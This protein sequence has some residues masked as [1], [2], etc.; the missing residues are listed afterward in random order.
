[1]EDRKIECYERCLDRIWNDLSE[2]DKIRLEGHL[3]CLTNEIDE[4][5]DL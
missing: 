4:I 2:K 3:N 5:D 1:M